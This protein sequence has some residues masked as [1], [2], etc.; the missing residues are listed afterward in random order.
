MGTAIAMYIAFLLLCR[1]VPQRWKLRFVG[2]G[3]ATDIGVHVVLQTMFGGDANG[4]AGLL[5][6]GILI[7]VTMHGYRKLF[8]YEK[9]TWD[10]WERYNA[11]DEHQPKTPA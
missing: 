9:L 7:N 11:K 10:G 8:G 4:R 2:Y 3:L 6:A 1:W 5:L